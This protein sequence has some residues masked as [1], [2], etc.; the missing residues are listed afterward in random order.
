MVTRLLCDI[1]IDTKNIHADVKHKP[2]ALN[3]MCLFIH[4]FT[5][6]VDSQ[7]NCF[8]NHAFPQV[9]CTLLY[10]Y[11]QSHMFTNDMQHVTAVVN[12]ATALKNQF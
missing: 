11:T 10:L 8:L 1:H 5:S 7:H 6:L 9:F 4:W 3:K 2:V 12:Q